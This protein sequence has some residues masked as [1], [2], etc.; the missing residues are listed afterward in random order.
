M[1]MHRLNVRCCC[2]PTKVLG[3]I[4]VPEIV[5]RGGF[6]NVPIPITDRPLDVVSIE[7]RK[8]ALGRCSDLERELGLPADR[9]FAVY[10]EERPIEF[11]RAFPSFRE[12]DAV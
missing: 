2:Q 12:G 9:E 5:A 6:F 1:R 7:V 11:W 10:S 8:I 4:E 3:T